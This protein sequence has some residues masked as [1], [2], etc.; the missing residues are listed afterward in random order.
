MKVQV[1]RYK[2]K[3]FLHFSKWRRGSS[4]KTILFFSWPPL[5]YL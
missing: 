3:F 4:H 1:L 5:P 2:K